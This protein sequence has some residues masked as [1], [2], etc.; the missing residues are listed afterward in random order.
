MKII[1]IPTEQT[2]AATDA[3]LV[4]FAMGAIA[5]LNRFGMQ[6]LWKIRIWCWLFAL[7]AIAAG[8]GT[9]VHGLVISSELKRLMWQ[10]LALS[11]ALSVGLL[12]VG[13]AHDIWGENVSRRWLPYIL[14]A[15]GILYALAKGVSGGIFIGM[16]F[17]ASAVF[18]T[19][20]G[21]MMLAIRG[22]LEG[23][24]LV[25]AGLV[26]TVI[27]GIIQA[28]RAVSFKFVWE[29]DHNGVFHLVQ[30]V[31]LYLLVLGVRKSFL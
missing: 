1:D 8:L 12:A 7:V 16:V 14:V 21:Y 10:P 11:L 28:S 18:F 20:G 6:D 19:L 17:A 30:L 2:T 27:A 25:T 13:A 15:T 29:F 31:A 23:A 9:V 4:V 22:R 3:L 5:Y 26:L 24:E